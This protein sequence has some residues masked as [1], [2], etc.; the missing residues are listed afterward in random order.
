MKNSTVLIQYG[1][2]WSSGVVISKDGYIITSAHVLGHKDSFLLN[3][4]SGTNNNN[5]PR[6]HP[7]LPKGE[8][9]DAVLSNF[10]T[11]S[12]PII[13]QKARPVVQPKQSFQ[14]LL[15][16]TSSRTVTT[17]STSI[18]TEDAF[19]PTAA[20]STLPLVSTV[21]TFNNLDIDI[22]GLGNV[23]GLSPAPGQ[24]PSFS[25]DVPSYGKDYYKFRDPFRTSL[26][27]TKYDPMKTLSDISHSFPDF[28]VKS[29]VEFFDN[30][31]PMEFERHSATFQSIKPTSVLRLT[32][33]YDEKTFSLH[34]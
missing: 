30:V 18:S 15:S 28:A 16:S 26:H 6:T 4:T 14:P 19:K 9:D 20:T 25:L 23:K 21:N 3:E 12:T 32:N 34:H 5:K 11:F 27:S 7:T 17:S 29:E 8:C 1:T 22:S 33:P 31:L 2:S 24:P 10:S 13:P